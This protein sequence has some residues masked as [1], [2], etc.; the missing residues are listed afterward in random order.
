MRSVVAAVNAPTDRPHSEPELPT[1][2]PSE[3][4]LVQEVID[5]LTHFEQMADSLDLIEP[6]LDLLEE[7]YGEEAV[8][9]GYRFY[10]A[11]KV[12]EERRMAAGD[13]ASLWD[14]DL[15]GGDDASNVI[16]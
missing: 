14:R 12:A 1:M 10:E 6:Y 16:R 2:L 11:L 13:G 3:R 8:R 7:E 9:W 5:R 4:R 15:D